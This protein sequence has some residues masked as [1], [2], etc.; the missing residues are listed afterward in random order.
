MKTKRWIDVERFLN[1]RWTH[2]ELKMNAFLNGEHKRTMNAERK[3]V[4]DESTNS[5]RRTH[6]ERTVSE[7]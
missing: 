4:Y 6:G 5:A 7:R 3:S 2:S 1:G